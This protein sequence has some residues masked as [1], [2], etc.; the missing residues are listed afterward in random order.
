MQKFHLK[1]VISIRQQMMTAMNFIDEH[2]DRKLF[3]IA[4]YICHNSCENGIYTSHLCF[5]T[6]TITNK[7]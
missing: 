4:I 2:F 5:K 1:R 6:T 7:H 3:D